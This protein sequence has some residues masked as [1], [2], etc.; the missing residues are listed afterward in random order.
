MIHQFDFDK[1]EELLRY[2]KRAK[3]QL[4][5]AERLKE[6]WGSDS[7]PLFFRSPYL[8]YEK[9]IKEIVRPEHY[10]LELGSGSGLHTHG[11]LQTGAAVTATDISPSS[12]VLL[13]Q[14][15][16]EIG[17]DRL[18]TQVADMED[19]PFENNSFDVIT[20]AGSLSYGDP[21]KVDA[22]IRRLLKTNGIFICV[23]SLHHN[24]VYKINRWINY[25]RGKRTKSTLERM[26]TLARIESIASN[27][28]EVECQ[29]FGSLSW[30]SPLLAK[31]LGDSQSA[32]FSDLFDQK[33]KIKKSAFKFVLIA[34]TPL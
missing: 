28:K 33:M 24:P 3:R 2:D 34:R 30:L 5:L 21:I 29:F 14:N 18:T 1:N 31:L 26:P 7:M 27:F 22:E 19:L 32:N 23:D 11:L 15:L 12:L 9:R 6:E 8:F 25:L 13:K 4:E 17:E 10:V 16:L 20:S